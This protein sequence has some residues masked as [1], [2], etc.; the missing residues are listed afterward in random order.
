[1]TAN[2]PADVRRVP[3]KRLLENE[4]VDWAS[5]R[6]DPASIPGRRMT[7]RESSLLQLLISG[8]AL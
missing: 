3:V 7:K 5:D 2:L 8:Y 4:L 6:V 1:M